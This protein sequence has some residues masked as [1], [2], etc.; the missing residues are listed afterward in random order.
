M[1]PKIEQFPQILCVGVPYYGDNKNGEIPATWPL[2]HSL[3][4]QVKNKKEPWIHLGVE[5]YTAEFETQRKWFHLAAV[6]V[7]SLDE[8]PIQL[9]GKILAANRYAIFTHKGK[10]PG[11]IMETFRYIYGEWLPRSRLQASRPI[12][13]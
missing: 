8:I 12:R 4:D 10:L 7:T 13:F 11:R 1:E 9:A 5:T 6:E 2:F 3:A